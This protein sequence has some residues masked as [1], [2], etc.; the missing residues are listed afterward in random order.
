MSARVW[1]WD[2]SALWA[3]KQGRFLSAQAEPS[4]C[5]AGQPDVVA[6][7]DVAAPVAAVAVAVVAGPSDGDDVAVGGG[8]CAQSCPLCSG[9]T[10]LSRRLFGNI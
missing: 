1:A 4:G 9:A 5:D 2:D 6:E 3:A 8:D 7:G 10:D